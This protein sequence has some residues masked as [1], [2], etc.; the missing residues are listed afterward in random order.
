MR[1][2]PPSRSRPAAPLPPAAR[3]ACALPPRRLLPALLAL[4]AAPGL[5]GVAAA[6]G[7]QVVTVD[8]GSFTVTRGG[9]K[10]GREEFRIVRQPAAGGVAYVARGVGAYGERRITP[11][12]QSDSI[13]APLRYQVEVR[14]TG[15]VDQRLTGQ[16]GGGRFTAQVQTPTGEASR[17]YL[18]PPA[19][20][21]LDDEVYHQYYFLALHRRRD[22][23]AAFPVLVPRRNQQGTMRVTASVPERLTIGGQPL[24]A[25]HLTLADPSGAR[26]DVWLDAQGRV[27]KVAVPA[28]DVVALRDDPPR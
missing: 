28:S 11:A 19:S 9:A 25:A 21:V 15:A 8:E 22:P 23:G 2:V 4:A 27:L 17:E 14:V 26:R 10:L 1:T 24:D 18:L 6:A 13:G 7:A 20:V 12:L 3:R 5:P 16:T